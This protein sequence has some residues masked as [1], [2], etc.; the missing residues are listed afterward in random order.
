V[1]ELVA[2]AAVLVM[3]GAAVATALIAAERAARLVRELGAEHAQHI[4]VLLERV[5]APP[6]T[7]AAFAA[8]PPEQGPNDADIDREWAAASFAAVPFDPDLDLIPGIDTE[9]KE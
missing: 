2:I 7:A 6:L 4:S 9:P 8:Q 3:A 5:Q 1:I